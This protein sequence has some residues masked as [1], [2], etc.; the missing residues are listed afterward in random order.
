[1]IY[2]NILKS[3][4]LNLYLRS[5]S[6]QDC[7]QK[8]L[9][10]LEN[11]KI[12]RYLETRLTKQSLEKIKAFV[13]TINESDHSYLF[14][15]FYN[16]THIGNIKL[17]PIHPE[18][19][20]ADISYFIGEISEQ[21]KGFATEAV[22]LLCDFGF[23]IKKLHRISAG[24]YATNLATKRVLEKNEFIFEGIYREK[25]YVNNTYIDAFW[26]AKLNKDI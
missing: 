26:C 11:P 6:E 22:R 21:G 15:I 5:L 24:G 20:F 13:N 12:N 14:G 18:Y 19:H 4:R 2:S 17:G 1:M 8:Y 10:W 7:T 16:D 3:D 25:I 23:R 9:S